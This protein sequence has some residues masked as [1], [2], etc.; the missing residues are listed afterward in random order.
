MKHPWDSQ[1]FATGARAAGRNPGVI[2]TAN[3]AAGKIKQVNPDLPVVLTLPHLGQLVDVAPETLSAIVARKVDPYRVFRVKKRARP[4]A[5][6]ST[7]S[8][9]PS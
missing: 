9:V 3:L 4:S 7:A 8:P 6:N 5:S 1:V 2:R